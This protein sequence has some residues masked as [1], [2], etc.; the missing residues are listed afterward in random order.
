MNQTLK[1]LQHVSDHADPS[2]GSIDSYLIKT[3]CSGS[4]VLV[5]R[6][7]GVWRHIHDLSCVC[8][9]V[10]HAHTPQALNLPPK[11]DS[12]HNKHS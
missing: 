6:A 12:A 2:S 1:L 7:V 11:T 4:A 5:V 3:T 10:Q 9:C 8:V